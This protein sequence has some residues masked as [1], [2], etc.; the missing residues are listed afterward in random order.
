MTS[1]AFDDATRAQVQAA[2]PLR[3]TWLTANAG[4]GK[5]R[6]LTDRVARLLLAGTAPE[7]ILC[8]TYTKAA[9]TEMQNRLLARL[10]K[11]AMLPEAELRAELARLG[12][13]RAPD[14]RAARRLFARAIE[15]PGG[16]K[17]QTIHSFCAGVLRRFPIEAG[18][19]HGFTELDDRSAALIRAE[20]IEDMA[21]EDA[22]EL[23]DL[24]ALHSGVQL[25][26]FLSG[27]K[28]FEEAADMGAIWT[29]CGLEPGEDLSSLIARTFADGALVIAALIPHL[30]KSG[31]NDQ[32]AAAKLSVGDWTRP[33]LAELLILETVLLNGDR[34]KE[35]FSGK[36]QTFPTKALR[37]GP[38]AE[39]IDDLMILIERVETSRPR[40]VALSHAERTLALH[41]FGHA[42]LSRYRGEKALRGYLDFDDLIDRTARL[43]SEGSM[44]QWVL[45]RL[46]GGI[47]HI[48]VD[49]A[50]DTSPG[51]W[52][53]IQSLTDEFTSG[54]GA[55]EA[56][57]RSLFV[58]GDPK[59]SIYSFQGAD[60]KV[61][62]D[63]RVGFSE[64]F[65]A[66]QNPMQVLELR[67]SFR[68]ST[69]I[70]S[71]VD[72][73]FAG[74]AS[75][76]LG[77]PPRH[78]AFRSGM[79]GRVD[80]WPP[81]PKPEKPEAGDWTDPVDQPA[82]NSATTQLARAI[83]RAV[84]DMLGSPIFDAKSGEV[85]Q[86]RAG[87][88]L[89]LVQRRSEIFAEVIAALKAASLPVAGA[90]RLKLAGEMA[91]R[92][93][94]AVL[95]VLATP[96]DD[97]ELAAALRS[98]LF[99][100][101]E[102][103]LYRLAAGRKK[104]EY[105]WR[106]LRDSHHR[107]AVDL[108]SDLMGQTG[109]MRPYDLI[110]RLLI[111]HGGRERLI[112][113]LG[114]EAEDGIDELL[115]QA[116]NYESSETPSLTGFLVWL[117]GDD[118]E[119]RRQPGSAGEDG[120]GLIRVMTVHGSKGLESPIVIMPDAAKRKPPREDQVMVGP[121][122][123]A[124]WRG[125]RGERPEM[126]EALAAERTARQLQERKRLLYVGLTRA[127]SWLIVAA[128]GVTD[129]ESW[130]SMVE[131]GV[132]RSDLTETRIPASWGGEIRRLAFG[133]WP[134][135]APERVQVARP[136]IAEP[137][138]LRAAPPPMPP[139]RRPV[140]AT[141]LGGAKV[142]PGQGEGDGEAAMLFGTRLHLLLEHL[143]GR[144]AGDW[145]AIARD[146]LADAEGG[147]PEPALLSALLDEV[148]EV[149]T[150]PA[151]SEVFEL[152]EGAEVFQ[153][154]ALSA[155]LPGI[156]MLWGKI[157]RL[158]V[159]P[160]RILAVDYKSNRDVPAR[161]EDTP[162]GILR[163]MAAYRAALRQLWPDRRVEATV[164][165]TAPRRLMTLPDPLLDGVIA[166]LDR[167]PPHA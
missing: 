136:E 5:T 117:S 140:A 100:I 50:Q 131:A 34:T 21:R 24:L 63:R 55:R 122:G 29:A 101:S 144:D 31:T 161:A 129:A 76:G 56:G 11:W 15:T 108:L 1:P 97:L 54:Q 83:A 134:E 27:L 110:Q 42:F 89:I 88:I 48:L 25:D 57:S 164:L 43:L 17:V 154:L 72:Q 160:D 66:V 113:R 51:Q 120:E 20:I 165:W 141:G 138:W 103:Q 115:S 91:V 28:G 133:D 156:G 73:V 166:A 121:G 99:G 84:R 92:D 67:H 162:L 37:N 23:A 64:A 68:S 13:A 146:L 153:E 18:V 60:I 26:G 126:V 4:S 143:P 93:I 158:V 145:P 86:I 38:C 61:F 82:E 65:A 49:E 53:V 58:V 77:D 2:D 128:A 41:R 52:Q 125:T 9:A 137:A 114:S 46:D 85:R 81:V 62:E 59:Q 159:A 74:A 150:A 78:L 107:A 33:G 95:S 151:L 35:P 16:L 98:P 44:A 152:P 3:S 19:P 132:S 70:L 157:D 127:E 30:L 39:L 12:E 79:P 106:R 96:E 36:Y 8:L 102:E 87:D 10:G 130:H 124:L 149:L 111:R 118:V 80:L 7:R 112:A 148:R 14:L 155:P 163:Q 47:D 6:V 94:R 123:M 139:K 32:K 22:P 109:F 119:V 167:T 40:R 116:M 135:T 105:L 75:D 69:A 104:G 71:L 90:D 45:F 142:M 147:L